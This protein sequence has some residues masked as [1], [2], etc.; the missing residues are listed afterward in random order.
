MTPGLPE[1][2]ALLRML[3]QQNAIQ[4]QRHHALIRTN[5]ANAEPKI[6]AWIR[7]L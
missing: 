7:S 5:L 3:E 1:I 2:G 4:F 6:R